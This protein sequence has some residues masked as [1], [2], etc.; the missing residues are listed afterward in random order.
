MCKYT[1]KMNELYTF[2]TQ[3]MNELAFFC[4]EMCERHLLT[5]TP[6]ECIT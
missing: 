5:A 3:K 4:V 6:L 1:Q 2:L